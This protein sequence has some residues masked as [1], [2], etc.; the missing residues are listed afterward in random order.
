LQ[1]DQ[2]ASQFRPNQTRGS[3]ERNCFARTRHPARESGE[4]TRAIA[5]HLGLTAISIVI[6]HPKVRAIRR[7]LE[8]EN[9]VRADAAMAIAQ[10]RNLFARERKLS[11]TIIEQYEIVPGAIHFRETEH[12]PRG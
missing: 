2:V 12:V 11:G 3:F 5:T 1:S 4:T 8:D 9:A 6:A 7:L 10:K